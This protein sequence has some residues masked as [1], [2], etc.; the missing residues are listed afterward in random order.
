MQACVKYRVNGIIMNPPGSVEPRPIAPAFC[1]GGEV[2]MHSVQ[3][4]HVRIQ[5]NEFVFVPLAP[6]MA[7]VP[8]ADQQGLLKQLREICHGFGLNGEVVAVWQGPSGLGYLAD[9]RYHGVLSKVLTMAVVRSNLNKK[10]SSDAITGL[11][12]QVALDPFGVP[13]TP[14]RPVSTSASE[15]APASTTTQ[16]VDVE[17]RSM[18]V[19]HAEARK[20]SANRVVTMLFTD[21]VGSTKLKQQYG[22]AHAMQLVRRHHELVRNILS[23]TSTGEEISTSGDSF[24]IAFATPSEAVTFALRMQSRVE[25]LNAQE[26]TNIQDR[27]GIHVGEV[28][29]DN[30]KVAG[31]T[32][33]LNGIQVDTAA[34]IMSLAQGK[35]ILLS[36]FAYD[37]AHQMLS[38]YEIDGIGDIEWRNHGLYEVKGVEN[39]VE[40]C[41]VGEVGFAPLHPPPDSDKAKRAGGSRR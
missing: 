6:M 41:E 18:P 22:D 11:L 13:S 14:G 16:A 1:R 38:G 12:A 7:G 15:R 32:F 28:Y 35:Q 25:D 5:G 23:A 31:K 30:A 24:F 19:F 40:I 26:G 37:N 21:L 8:S 2:A 17:H 34:R 3:V 4:A 36:R 33:D 20:A 27:V 10:V 29:A 39:L 9:S